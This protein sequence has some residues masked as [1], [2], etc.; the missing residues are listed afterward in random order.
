MFS[1][2]LILKSRLEWSLYELLVKFR[3]NHWNIWEYIYLP[4]SIFSYGRLYVLC[5]ELLRRK[6]L[7]I[8]VT[9]EKCEYVNVTS[10]VVYKEIFQNVL[11]LLIYVSKLSI[12]ILSLHNLLLLLFFAYIMWLLINI[13][14]YVNKEFT[15]GCQL[16]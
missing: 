11:Y 5:L 14:S 16:I 15:I 7:K 1:K 12:I 10:N 6:G 3:G 13:T 8:L 4:Q 9:D 2:I